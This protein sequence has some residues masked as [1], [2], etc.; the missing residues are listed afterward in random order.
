MKRSTELALS[1]STPLL[2]GALAIYLS[3]ACYERGRADAVRRYREECVAAGKRS[4]VAFTLLYV[5]EY[6]ASN[7]EEAIR[8]I[9]GEKMV[10]PIPE[11]QAR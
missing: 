11:W 7:C 5:D 1:V 2:L 6:N 10:R 4:E 3:I 9:W 8:K